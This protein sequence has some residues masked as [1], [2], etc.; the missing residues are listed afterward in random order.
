[1]KKGVKSEMRSRAPLSD[2]NLVTSINIINQQQR[3]ISDS[4]K[5]EIE[6]DGGFN[7]L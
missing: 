7:D 4:I 3:N 6:R 2:G 1:M 5:T